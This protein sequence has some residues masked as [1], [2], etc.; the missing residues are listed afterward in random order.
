MRV[1]SLEAF[2]V[3]RKMGGLRHVIQDPVVWQRE[4]RVDRP[5][6]GRN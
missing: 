4:Q 2:K 6:P 1:T 5:L 3:L